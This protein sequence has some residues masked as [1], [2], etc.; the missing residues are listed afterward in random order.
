MKKYLFL[1]ATVL[2]ST[3]AITAH[4]IL[5]DHKSTAIPPGA[6]LGI[7]DNLSSSDFMTINISAGSDYF[8]YNN[9]ESMVSE[10]VRN[11]LDYPRFHSQ[12][13]NS[14]NGAMTSPIPEPPVMMLMGLGLIGLA[15]MGR[16]QFKIKIDA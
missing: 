5:I 3:W 15:I 7:T 11:I 16:K 6:V 1:L 2:V 14:I 13:F 12:T 10:I 4:A 9:F 8:F